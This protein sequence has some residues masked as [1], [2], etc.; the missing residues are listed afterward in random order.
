MN[1][2]VNAVGLLEVY[3]LVTAFA[4]ADAAC[5]AANVTIEAFDKNKPANTEGLKVPLL[6][7]V[8]LR[9]SIADIEAAMEAGQIAAATLGGVVSKHVIARPMADTE[10]ILKIN[11]LKKS[12]AI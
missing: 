12:E 9:G 7:L 6:V 3:G 10:K 2:A 11:A 4:A 8:K 1:K 5:K